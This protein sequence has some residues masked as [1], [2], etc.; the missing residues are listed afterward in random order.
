MEVLGGEIEVAGAEFLN[1]PCNLV[2]ARPPARR[3]PAPAVD[4]PLRPPLLRG[5]APAAE[6]PLAHPQQRSS[7]HAAQLLLPM[8]L[9]RIS[10][11]GHPDLRQHAIPPAKTGQI[12]CYQTWTYLVSATQPSFRRLTSGRK[13]TLARPEQPR[14]RSRTEWPPSSRWSSPSSGDLLNQDRETA[15]ERRHGAQSP[16]GHEGAHP[17]QARGHHGPHAH[18]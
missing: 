16:D 12:V 14:P 17:P 15:Q 2:H 8:Q 11:P 4:D 7:L 10:D 6:M 13:S 3:P 9:H 1:H 18:K 5:T